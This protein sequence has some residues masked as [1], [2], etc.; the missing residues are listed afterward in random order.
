MFP[1]GLA[2]GDDQQLSIMIG[3]KLW[4]DPDRGPG[5]DLVVC[6]AG[7]DLGDLMGWLMRD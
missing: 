7:D 1:D 5:M 3:R 2:Y 6:K 4:A